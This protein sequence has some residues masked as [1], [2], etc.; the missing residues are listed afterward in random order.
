MIT[1]LVKSVEGCCCGRGCGAAADAAAAAGCDCCTVA[2]AA[3]A[4]KAEKASCGGRVSAL[5]AAHAT[6][7]AVGDHVA[8]SENS[9]TACVATAGST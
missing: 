3:S 7:V 9:S 4:E 8:V 1:S 2:G 6:V 5:A